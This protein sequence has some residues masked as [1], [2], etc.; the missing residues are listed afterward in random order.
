[1]R[2]RFPAYR[3]YTAARIEVNDAVMALL[4][5]ARLGEHALKSSAAD[6]DALLPALFGRI[7][8]INRL[9]RTPA[10]AAELLAGAETHLAY[11]AL[12]YA[13]AVHHVFI[14]DALRMLREDGHDDPTSNYEIPAQSDLAKLPLETAHEYMSERCA[15]PLDSQLL[16]LFHLLRRLR[17]RVIHA[18]GTAGSHLIADYKKLPKQTRADWERLAGRSLGADVSGEGRLEL[19]EGELV[20][21]LAIPHFIAQ[22]VNYLLMR[23]LSREFWAHVAVDDYRDSF[24]AR[25][26]Q[27]DRRMPRLMGHAERLYGPLA[28]TQEEIAAELRR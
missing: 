15:K 3:R 24:P 5:G 18:G 10:D 13:L 17:N 19:R 28:L 8:S 22:E 2:V 11:M 16:E 1:V 7:E 21:A 4:V 23:T 12:P 14:I 26:A 25:F 20:A 9:N 27:R 6:P